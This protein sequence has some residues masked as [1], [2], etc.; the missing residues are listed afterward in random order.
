[1]HQPAARVVGRTRGLFTGT[2][3][4]SA[5]WS[6][7]CGAITTPTA[8]PHSAT[9]EPTYIGSTYNRCSTI[10]AAPAVLITLVMGHALLPFNKSN[11]AQACTSGATD[12]VCQ[13]GWPQMSSKGRR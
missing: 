10:A 4:M 11:A 8:Q 9:G 7:V 5:A 13:S 12:T 6:A 1:V 3:N 2:A